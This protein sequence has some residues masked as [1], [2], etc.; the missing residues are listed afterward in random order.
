MASGI[1]RARWKE[2]FVLV[3]QLLRSKGTWER[4]RPKN[5]TEGVLTSGPGWAPHLPPQPVV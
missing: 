3:G 4:C 2:T 5:G 1:K